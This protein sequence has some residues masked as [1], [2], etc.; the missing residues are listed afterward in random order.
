MRLPKNSF[1]QGGGEGQCSTG[2]TKSLC[3]NRV[4]T[5]SHHID[6]VARHVVLLCL[7]IVCGEEKILDAGE[8][9]CRLCSTGSDVGNECNVLGCGG[10][11]ACAPALQEGTTWFSAQGIACEL[12]PVAHASASR[13]Q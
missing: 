8:G 10:M 2:R 3:H 7:V 1:E 9:S 5:I 11:H 6:P 12:T 13:E 4:R